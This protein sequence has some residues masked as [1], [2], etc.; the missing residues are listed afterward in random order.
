LLAALVIYRPFPEGLRPARMLAWALVFRAIGAA[1]NPILEDDHHRYLWDGRTFAV[2]GNPYGDLPGDHFAD[3]SLEPEFQEVLDNINNPDVPTIYGPVCQLAFLLAHHAA[4]ARLLP[5]KL[6]LLAADLLTLAVLLRLA[7]PH[8]VLLYAWCPLLIQETAFTAH[9]DSLGIALAVAAL[10][11][12]GRGA[13]A[14]ASVL[15]ALAIGARHFVILLAPFVLARARGRDRALFAGTLAALYLP[16]VLQGTAAEW[17]GLSAFLGRWEFNSFI[18][19]IVSAAGGP[20]LARALLAAAFLVLYVIIFWRWRRR[21]GAN[22]GGVD[23]DAAAAAF[24]RGDWIYGL[25]FLLSPVVNPW[26]LLWL[27]PFVALRPSAWGVA[28]LAA[29]TL[30]YAHGLHL[31]IPDLAPYEH[32]AWVRPAELGLVAAAWAVQVILE[33]VFRPAERDAEREPDDEPV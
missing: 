20:R 26:Y 24:P 9:P 13:H 27:L 17:E 15:A 30:S 23:G 11:A 32:P 29:V 3:A 6:L 21:Q 19:G 28:A 4:P 31:G 14:R 2:R 25:F 8:L 7:A 1:G 22:R 5:L 18:F 10:Y 12:S 33:R 16:F